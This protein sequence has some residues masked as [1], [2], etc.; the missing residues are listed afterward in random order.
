MHCHSQH[1][2]AVRFRYQSVA[3]K[4]IEQFKRSDRVLE[5]FTSRLRRDNVTLT[6]DLLTPK[7]NQF[8]FVPRPKMHQ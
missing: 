3:Y 8:I 7:P 6:C 4:T 2:I 5:S 1:V